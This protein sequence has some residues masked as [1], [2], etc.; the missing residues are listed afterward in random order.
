MSLAASS[1]RMESSLWA[2][3]SVTAIEGVAPV[4][5]V[6]VGKEHGEEKKT[7]EEV[8]RKEEEE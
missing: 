8:E 3:P 1:G 5:R 6:T 7:R 2:S 4:A